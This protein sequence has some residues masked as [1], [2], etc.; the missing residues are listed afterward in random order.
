MYIPNLVKPM[1]MPS[2][3]PSN[4]TGSASI[5]VSS[6]TSFTTTS[7]A[8]Y[9]TSAQPVG[10]N[11]TPLGARFTNKISPASLPTI[12]P[13]AT[14]GVTYPGMPSPMLSIHSCTKCPRSRRSSVDSSNAALMSA[15]TCNTSSYRS[16]SYRFWVNAKPVRAIAASDSLH[17]ASCA[18][19]ELSS[20]LTPSQNIRARVATNVPPVSVALPQ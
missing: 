16:R 11:H 13:I 10:Y 6:R 12:A 9:P 17:R 15:A 18:S 20:L 1:R 8:E 4:C 7:A 2:T 5:P 14:F 19:S 3:T